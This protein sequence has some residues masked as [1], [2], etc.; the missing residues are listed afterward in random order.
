MSALRNSSRLK[1]DDKK[2]LKHLKAVTVDESIEKLK[3][4]LKQ[5]EKVRRSIEDED[6]DEAA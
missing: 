5:L 1:K 6:F 3:K 4:V 2:Q